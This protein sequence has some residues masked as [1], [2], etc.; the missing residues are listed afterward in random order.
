MISNGNDMVNRRGNEPTTATISSVSWLRKMLHSSTVIYKQ[1]EPYFSWNV[2]K[3]YI[4]IFFNLY[5][6]T[7]LFDSLKI[8]Q[9][10]EDTCVGLIV[11]V[12]REIC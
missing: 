5:N 1:R 9:N 3:I 4:L 2:M 11:S 6:M 10:L 7:G 8:K 12:R